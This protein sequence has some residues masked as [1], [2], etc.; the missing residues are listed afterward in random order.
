MNTTEQILY[1]ILQE[2]Q[3]LND[4]LGVGEEE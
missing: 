4:H 2:L 1:L 3:K